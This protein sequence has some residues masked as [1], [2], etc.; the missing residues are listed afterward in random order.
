MRSVGFKGL[1][2]RMRAVSK[3]SIKALVGGIVGLMG[4]MILSLSLPAALDA[5]KTVLTAHS[6]VAL[7]ETSRQLLAM[8]FAG[9]IERGDNLYALLG[10]GPLKA[11]TQ[12]TIAERR[13][14]VEAGYNNSLKLI[15]ALQIPDLAAPFV[16]YQQSYQAMAAL[17]PSVDQAVLLPRSS[18]DA[19][20]AGRWRD[21]A[22]HYFS[23]LAALLDVINHAIE[24]HDP[25]IDKLLMATRAATM[26]QVDSSAL[27]TIISS[28]VATGK[29]WTPAES[30]KAAEFVGR[31][32]ADW[33]LLAQV[34]T[35]K[36]IT[37]GFKS[38]FENARTVYI[39]EEKPFR[40]TLIDRLSSGLPPD[41]QIDAWLPHA[42][43]S[44][45]H[46]SKAATAA[47]DDVVLVANRADQAAWRH[48]IFAF[49][50]LVVAIM[51]TLAGLL[52]VWRRVSRPLL[53]L[54][55]VM[56]R[57]ADRDFAAEV[58][59]TERGDELG[60]IARAV[61]VFRENGLSMQQLE[62]EAAQTRRQADL[63]REGA[64]AEQAE[65]V[66]QQNAVV[67]ALRQGLERLAEGDLTCLINEPLA[68]AEYDRLR[69]DFNAAVTGLREAIGDVVAHTATIQ[70][71]TQE[72]A[73][74]SDDLSRRTERQAAGLE[75]TAAALQQ[76]TATVRRTSEGGQEARSLA[77]ATRDDAMQSEQVVRD[78]V[79]AM[80]A[81]EGSA[82]QISQIIGVIDEIAFQTNLLALN[83]GVEAARAGESGRGFA[84][85]AREV[86]ALAQRSAD[87]AKEIKTL[88]HASEQQVQRGVTLVGETG[89]AL[90]RILSKV[91]TIS[92]VISE[93]ATSAQQQ[94]T[95]LAEVNTAVAEMDTVTQ[96]NAAMVEQT[97]A[98]THSL[99]HETEE[100]TRAI[101][102]F[103]VAPQPEGLSAR[104]GRRAA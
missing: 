88:I 39:D 42:L 30:Q 24:L 78:A 31:V 48:L 22:E 6:L 73:S 95:G 41:I 99:S 94:A 82:R 83:A 80:A 32:G 81:I 13:A 21:A 38:S 2:V 23:A 65:R 14:V 71:G 10:E 47:L 27:S 1:K 40:Q 34:A 60:A 62:T 101:A 103:Q 84:V 9:R 76:I 90:G 37:A 19:A 87:A 28:S 43:H 57:L 18:R 12:Q 51:L 100:L 36:G 63:A 69:L 66:A 75:Q 64:A 93:I 53:I 77:T 68:P 26:L 74:A 44:S 8:T 25:W 59:G 17:R 11:A 97:T 54:T 52:L 20:L 86:R 102:R 3:I 104:G 61:A 56:G 7:S 72:I 96:Q 15:A 55:Q 85:V 92:Q 4:L 33:D 70:T 91:G 98:A 79:A 45:G 16:S 89:A 35:T 67:S 49:S 58:T 50:V 5:L 29:V 46:F